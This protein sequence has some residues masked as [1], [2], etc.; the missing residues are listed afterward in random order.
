VRHE[1][2]QE[3]RA[4]CL[5]DD[6]LVRAVRAREPRED[7]VEGA[8][9]AADERPRAGEQLALGRSTSGRF[10]TIRNGSDSS[11]PR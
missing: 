2:P 9:R 10:G 8:D 5:C 7:I 4:L 3:Q 6:R 11:A 1:A